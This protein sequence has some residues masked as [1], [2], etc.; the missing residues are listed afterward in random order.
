MS[1]KIY[2]EGGGE[3]KEMHARCREG[4][5]RLLEKCSLK[6]R[7]PRLVACGGRNATFDDFSTAHQNN[8]GNAYIALLVDSE[9]SV[10]DIE[11]P[12]AHLKARDKWDKPN[13]AT[14]EQ[15]LFMT[16][17]M[18]SWIA[19]DRPTLRKHYG[20]TLRESA[21]PSLEGME[22]RDRHAVQDALVNATRDCKNA[23]KKGK[24]S[25]DVVAE[26]SPDE[27]RKHLPNFE[28]FER[29]LKRKL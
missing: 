26:L 29:V 9:D 11:Q 12:W 22:A 7:M 1:A 21:L 20:S 18:E 14:D 15:V 4:F 2:V 23:Y 17:C 19:S 24:R 13:G 27:L 25:F 10:A 6:D 5:R 28:R 8:S 3:S 16:T